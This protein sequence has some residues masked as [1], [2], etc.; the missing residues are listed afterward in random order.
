MGLAWG[1]EEGVS[2]RIIDEGDK[3]DETWGYDHSEKAAS[4]NGQV[5]DW[6]DVDENSEFPTCRFMTCDGPHSFDILPFSK[7]IG[8][9]LSY[10]N[11]Q[12]YEFLHPHN[13]D[14]PYV[15]DNFLWSHCSNAGVNIAN[16]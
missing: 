11:A 6:T 9:D 5:C 10:T 15:Y 4:D 3:F 14:L 12:F 13:D 7:F 8:T 1:D 2:Q 16:P